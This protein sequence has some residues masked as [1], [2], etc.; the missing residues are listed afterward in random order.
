MTST[1]RLYDAMNTFVRQCDIQWRD[2][3]DG[4]WRKMSLVKLQPGQAY[5][6]P[7]ITIDKTRP[8]ERV[9][10]AFTH[11]RQSRKAWVIVSD[12]PTTL[13]P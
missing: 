5:F 12:E 13:Q 8:Y 6:T 9:Y 7:A 3:R 4:Q 1:S 10:L 11:D 2:L